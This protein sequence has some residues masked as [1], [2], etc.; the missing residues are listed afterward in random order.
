MVKD[1]LEEIL[2][3]SEE[4][5]KKSAEIE[6]KLMKVYREIVKE[7][8]EKHLKPNE[9]ENQCGHCY[10]VL[11][12]PKNDDEK[13]HEGV[14]HHRQKLHPL[15]RPIDG[16]YWIGKLELAKKSQ[17]FYAFLEGFNKYKK[18]LKD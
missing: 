9:K 14:M 10:Q 7:C 3:I 13:E 5:I 12:L 4:E 2:N 11:I 1:A 6:K 17:K 8:K 16:A 15:N 18:S